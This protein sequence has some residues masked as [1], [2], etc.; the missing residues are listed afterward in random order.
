V[1]SDEDPAV[2]G[3]PSEFDAFLVLRKNGLCDHNVLA[4]FADPSVDYWIVDQFKEKFGENCPDC[5]T[6]HG[7]YHKTDTANKKKTLTIGFQ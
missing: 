5:Y 3:M 1:H 6:S 7:R 4:K 2:Q